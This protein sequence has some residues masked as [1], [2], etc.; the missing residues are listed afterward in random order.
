M[1]IDSQ[2]TL[3]YDSQMTDKYFAEYTRIKVK[4]F[5]E[6][7]LQ[8][9]SNTQESKINMGKALDAGLVVKES[10]GTESR[11]QDTSSKPGNDAYTDNADIKPVYDEEPMPKVQLIAECNIFATGQQHIEQPKI[12]NEGRVDQYPEQCQVQS[13]M[14][15]SS[16]DNTTTEFLNQSLESKNICLKKTVAQFQKVFSRIEAHFIALELKY[17]NQALKSG[18]HGQFLKE[19][20][21]EAKIKHDIDETETINFELERIQAKDHNDSLIVQMNNKSTENA[22]LKAQLQEKVFAIAALKNELRKL[23]GNSVD[24]KFAKPYFL[25]KPVLKPLRNQTVNDLSKPVTQ[26]YFP[27]GRKSAFAKP[28]HVIASSASRNSSKNM[29]RFSL[30]DMVHHHYLEEAKKKTKEKD[31]NSKSSVMLSTSLQN[32]TN[33]SKPKPRSN[34]QI[35][36]SL[37]V[38]KSSCVMSNVVPLVDHSRKSS[39]FLDFKHFV[40]STCHKCVFNAN[41]DPYITKILK[42]V[43]SRAKVKSHK[44]RNNNKPVDQKSHIQKPN[45]QIF[46]GHR[47]SS[48]KSSAAYEKTSPRSCLRWKPMGRIFKTVGLRNKELISVQFKPRNIMST[49]VPTTDIIVMKSMIELESLF[50]SLFDEYFNGEN[51]VVSKSSAVTT[52]DASDKRQQQPDSTSSTSTLATTVTTDGNCDL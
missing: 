2:F 1:F 8:H 47:F 37:L 30:N 20:S 16:L 49:K 39:T 21:N 31:R 5:R 4:Q 14:L 26:H 36:R 50:S 38:C 51:Q 35:N 52:A 11:K 18:Q 3:D 7:L 40:C 17:Q 42:E 12:I 46:T 15:D 33:G 10:S 19:K 45:R 29:P 9:M 41:H 34:N 13:P 43:N 25:G 22:N 27:K 44:T 28:H 32:T 24:T 23:K 48:N 6:T